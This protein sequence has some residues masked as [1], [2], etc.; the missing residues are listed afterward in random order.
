MSNQKRS[1]HVMSVVN[2]HQNQELPDPNKPS[3]S[4]GDPALQSNRSSKYLL[5]AGINARDVAKSTPYRKNDG[6]ACNS[7][8]LIW[9]IPDVFQCLESL[10]ASVANETPYDV[11]TYADNSFDRPLSEIS[12][13]SVD[14]NNYGCVLTGAIAN[15]STNFYRF[16]RSLSMGQGLPAQSFAS[17]RPQYQQNID[18]IYDQTTKVV[19]RRRNNST[20]DSGK[21]CLSFKDPLGIYSINA[22]CFQMAPFCCA[23]HPRISASS[24]RMNYSIHLW[25][26]IHPFSSSIKFRWPRSLRIIRMT[27]SV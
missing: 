22:F 12:L 9:Q 5:S 10:G 19:L 23:I 15:K 13:D 18:A 11:L 2:E 21:F 7:P 20:C 26:Q 17:N 16:H 3:T 25:L 6:A 24:Y 8:E 14:T 4:R 27:V 1:P